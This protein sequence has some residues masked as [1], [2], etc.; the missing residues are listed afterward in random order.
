[1]TRLFLD[2][3]TESALLDEVTQRRQRLS[4][5]RRAVLPQTALLAAS[6]ADAYP[7]MDA[8]AIQSL[9]QAGVPADQPEAQFAGSLAARQAA[10]DGSLDP[11]AE[12][13]PD[14]WLGTLTDIVLGP[15]KRYVRAGFLILATPLQEVQALLSS[16]GVA[17]FDETD[18]A[19]PEQIFKGAPVLGEI[20][21]IL[22]NL[23]TLVSDVADVG[24]LVS[25]FWTNYTEKAARSGGLLALGDLLAGKRVDIGEGFLPAGAIFEERERAK[26]RLRIDD[27]FATPGRLIARQM[28]EPGTMAWQ[29]V[30]GGYD[31]VLNVADPVNIGLFKLSKAAKAANTF[32]ATG[33]VA[34]LR[35]TV[36]PER[37]VEHYLTSP[38][39]QKLVRVMTENTQFETA[40]RFFPDRETALN[41]SRTTDEAHTFKVLSDVLGTV[42]RE[43]PTAGFV[44]RQI[45][46]LGGNEYGALFGGGA[47]VRRA[48]DNSTM[49]RLGRLGRLGDDMPQRSI[50]INDG[51]DAMRQL[52]LWMRNANTPTAFRRRRM[53]ELALVKE[54]DEVGMLKTVTTIMDDTEGMLINEWGVSPERAKRVT[55]IFENLSDDLRTYDLDALGRNVDVLAPLRLQVEGAVVDVRPMPGMVSELLHEII[56]LP[57]ARTIRRLTPTMRKSQK[58]FDSGL[59]TSTIDVLD[60]S[61][62]IVWKPMQ[63]LRLAYPTRVIGEEQLRMGASGYDSPITLVG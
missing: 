9:V 10:E 34:G 51:N 17:V 28:T 13:V 62:S 30:S 41:L 44:S 48:I 8:S 35:K 1:M 53:A 32:R 59:W 16:A 33:V 22:R 2:V 7:W 29:M 25:D 52:D 26:Q 23:G 58:W 21:F 20:E 14:G 24:Q 54:G 42:I 60:T 6:Y 27:Q 5:Q 46:G 4:A 56:P 36:A 47:R 55:S 37:A 38:L 49:G 50:N 19:G 11:Q 3:A 40:W 18:P 45:G 31:F 61:M 57:D 63:L 43:K 39:G 15:T 12:D